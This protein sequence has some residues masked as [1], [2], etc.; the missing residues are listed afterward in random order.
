M[1][2]ME[3]INLVP[4]T[5]DI[6][7]T[8]DNDS[9]SQ[10]GA[11]SAQRDARLRYLLLVGIALISGWLTFSVG[12]TLNQINGDLEKLRATIEKGQIYPPALNIHTQSKT[13]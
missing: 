9:A 1:K 7:S 13:P 3:S 10:T 12:M 6:E 2:A 4:H 8:T 11:V 5:E